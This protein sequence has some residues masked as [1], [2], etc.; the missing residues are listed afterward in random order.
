MGK[1]LRPF[2]LLQRHPRHVILRTDKK[3]AGGGLA[4]L[5]LLNNPTCKLR[6]RGTGGESKLQI[7][8]VSFGERF[9]HRPHAFDPAHSAGAPTKRETTFFL[10]ALDELWQSLR[11]NRS[12]RKH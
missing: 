10:G 7:N 3:I 11:K 12:R 5:C 9:F 2:E 1:S 4:G 8:A 6:H